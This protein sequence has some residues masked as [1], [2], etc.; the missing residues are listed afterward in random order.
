MLDGQ[1]DLESLAAILGYVEN[2]SMA[3]AIS[4]KAI[5]F[6]PEGGVEIL[7]D[8]DEILVN[9]IIGAWFEARSQR[10]TL[11]KKVSED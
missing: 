2:W 8:M 7:D 3:N 10:E 9:W 1:S 11:S 6:D 5:P 4:G